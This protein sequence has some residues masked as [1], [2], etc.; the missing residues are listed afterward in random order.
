MRMAPRAAAWVAW[1]EWTCNTP[2]QGIRSKRAGLRIRS[3]FW[4]A[5]ASKYMQEGSRLPAPSKRVVTHENHSARIC[6][7]EADHCVAGICQ[8]FG[9]KRC[10]HPRAAHAHTKRGTAANDSDKN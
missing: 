5:F 4:P 9:A 6:P 8:S 10:V 7:P 2:H 3:F 1:A